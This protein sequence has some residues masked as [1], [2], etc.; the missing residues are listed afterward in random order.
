MT[1]PFDVGR[2]F[3]QTGRTRVSKTDPNMVKL[4]VKIGTVQLGPAERYFRGE[5]FM[6]AAGE[7][8]RLLKVGTVERVTDR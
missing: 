2:A 3:L 4:R 8:E 7:A 1:R 6:I 5:T